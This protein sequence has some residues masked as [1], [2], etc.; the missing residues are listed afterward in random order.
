MHHVPS[1]ASTI[2]SQQHFPMLPAHSHSSS[3]IAAG[4][5]S[6]L[7]PSSSMDPDFRGHAVDGQPEQLAQALQAATRP[8]SMAGAIA[9]NVADNSDAA[10]SEIA[11]KGLNECM[12]YLKEAGALLEG[13]DDCPALKAAF[14]M[15]EKGGDIVHVVANI[16]IPP[17]GGQ[18]IGAVLAIAI[19]VLKASRNVTACR[20]LA[21]KCADIMKY[22]VQVPPF[23]EYPA[24]S[25]SIPDNSIFPL[26]STTSH[27]HNTNVPT[28][29]P[30]IKNPTP[31]S[32]AKTKASAPRKTSRPS[33][34]PP[35]KILL[36][37]PPLK[38]P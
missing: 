1:Q 26:A 13:I 34:H 7:D 8:L 31:A 9:D 10:N 33:I 5:P 37:S 19:L 15:F 38:K 11:V 20:L 29:V 21:S 14:D 16:I 28:G 35:S 17:P 36:W 27:P 25:S 18:V 32:A 6:P 30:L 22:I 4:A 12:D 3:R 2:P 24:S 23:A